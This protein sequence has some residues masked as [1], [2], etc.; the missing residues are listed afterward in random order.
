ML[1][2]NAISK[3]RNDVSSSVF[4]L[5]KKDCF[6]PLHSW[7]RS[8][9]KRNVW[10]TYSMS[11]YI[12][13]ACAKNCKWSLLAQ[14][15]GLLIWDVDEG[16]YGQIHGNGLGF[17][18]SRSCIQKLHASEYSHYFWQPLWLMKDSFQF[19]AQEIKMKITLQTIGNYID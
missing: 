14:S 13:N 6:F 7:R 2:V 1:R 15:V 8:R 12:F 4:F 5:K 16:Q 19:Q 10:T 9:S 3:H 11:G 17:N 18:I